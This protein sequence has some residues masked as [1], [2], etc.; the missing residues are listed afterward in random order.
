MGV[1]LEW[2]AFACAV[3]LIC[4]LRSL[5]VSWVNWSQGAAT[6][7]AFGAPLG[8]AFIASALALADEEIINSGMAD[9]AILAFYL[10][11]I[12]VGG[13]GT[14][15]SKLMLGDFGSRRG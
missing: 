8:L 15:L 13:V 6:A 12:A 14:A 3:V 7:A 4:A 11:A 1:F 10:T 2:A 5:L 9:V